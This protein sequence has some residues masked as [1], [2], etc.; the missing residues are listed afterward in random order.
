[1]FKKRLK[2][3]L[4]MLL[5]GSIAATAVPLTASA[6]ISDNHV[7]VCDGDDTKVVDKSEYKTL[8]L[9]VKNALLRQETDSSGDDRH[10]SV[11]KDSESPLDEGDYYFYLCYYDEKQQSFKIS[12]SAMK[13]ENAVWDE[14]NTWVTADPT[15][16]TN[17]LFLCRKVT[18]NVNGNGEN[19][20]FNTKDLLDYLIVNQGKYT[21]N[22]ALLALFTAK[23]NSIWEVNPRF[24]ENPPFYIYQKDAATSI[25]DF[26][27]EYP[28]EKRLNLFE[29]SSIRVTALDP[30][31]NREMEWGSFIESKLLDENGEPRKISD[32]FNDLFRAVPQEEGKKYDTDG[33]QLWAAVTSCGGLYEFSKVE[34]DKKPDSIGVTELNKMQNSITFVYFP[35]VEIAPSLEVTA[36]VVGET[37]SFDYTIKDTV[38]GYSVNRVEWSCDN[39]LLSEND[40]FEAGKEYTVSVVLQP[41][42]GLQFAETTK[43]KINGNDATTTLNP[44]DSTLEV[45]YTFEALTKATPY[46]KTAPTA[47]AITY[48]ETLSASTLKDAVVC[49]SESDKK[50]VAGTFTWKEA[51]TKP[52]VADSN[53]TEYD[54]VF[55]PTDAKNYNTVET[56]ITLIVNKAASAPGLPNKTME[57]DYSKK[58]VSDITTLPEGW[59]WQDE[60]K[61]K[62]L[63]VGTAVKA[64][65]VYTGADK[66]N[67]VT[68]SVEVSITRQACTH[69]WDGGV[70][71]KEATATQK[72]EK[73]YTCTVCKETKT[74]EVPALGAPK[75]GTEDTSD[76]G[77]ATYKVT[78]AS[79]TKGT[80]TYVAPTNKKKTT[81]TIPATVIID[82]VN[83]KVTSIADNAFANNKK[84]IKITIGS[85]VT[86]IGKKAFYKCTSLTKITIPSKVKKIGKQASYGCKKLKTITIKT[87]KLNSKNV[88]SKAFKGIYAKATIKVPKSK[89]KSYKKLL[90]ARGVG[91]KA[92]IKK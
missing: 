5:A 92:K 11:S 50:A 60:D 76:D 57:V 39:T 27:L 53:K 74:E 44:T 28:H 66:G 22:P 68:E 73:T 43:V 62:A 12:N 90:K 59:A 35:Q 67:Y 26:L 82:G 32:H 55:T 51:A 16:D 25:S 47:T 52:T 89:L 6:T 64:T 14:I 1:M 49:Y 84:L 7:S 36:P 45:S 29:Q 70:V 40:K 17:K 81:V 83:Y 86:T 23:P 56:K 41:E 20:E 88:G 9:P 10:I 24:T 34:L 48:G 63:T 21:S 65:A 75:V 38:G 18:V 46:I 91:K 13:Y 80:V 15:L 69:T 31:T 61:D 33:W 19:S 71:T 8:S 2:G 87:T 3:L 77:K 54:V 72:G 58:K 79:L 42:A 37:P 4:A 85:N 30:K 78:T